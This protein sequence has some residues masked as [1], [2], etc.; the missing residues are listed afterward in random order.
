MGLTLAVSRRALDDVLEARTA[1]GAVGSSA[2]FGA[3]ASGPTASG[4]PAASPHARR[5]APTPRV[6]PHGTPLG[7]VGVGHEPRARKAP[8]R[9]AGL[10]RRRAP[11]SAARTTKPGRGPRM[12]PAHALRHPPGSGRAA[13]RHADTPAGAGPPHAWPWPPTWRHAPRAACGLRP[14]RRAA[15]GRAPAA[16]RRAERAGTPGPGA[17]RWSVP[18]APPQGRGVPRGASAGVGPHPP[19][20]RH[21]LRWQV[22]P[23]SGSRRQPRPAAQAWSNPGGRRPAGGAPSLRRVCRVD[24][25]G[26]ERR[27]RWLRWTTR[28]PPTPAAPAPNARPELRLEA[29]AR[30]ERTLEAVSSRPLFGPV[31]ERA[32]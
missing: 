31:P 9:A 29:G 23:P 4:V 28:R 25:A 3:A 6:R 16:G 20:G 5:T 17:W 7:L 26:G 19:D 15:R 30:Y 10:G 32:A 14:H 13:T 11:T 12:T 8:C 24:P 1:L 18:R 27:T 2:W 21:A 22:P